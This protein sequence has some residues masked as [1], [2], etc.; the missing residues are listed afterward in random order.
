MRIVGNPSR[1]I[2]SPVHSMGPG[3]QLVRLGE[4]LPSARRPL[5]ANLTVRGILR[6]V[7]AQN[8]GRF[9][10]PEDQRSRLPD[11]GAVAHHGEAN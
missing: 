5:A 3:I 10:A 7:S 8:R 1:P 2:L 9:L 4:L 6:S 11:N